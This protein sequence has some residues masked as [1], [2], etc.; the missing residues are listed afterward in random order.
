MT[1]NKTI[2]TFVLFAM[3]PLNLLTNRGAA[4][5]QFPQLANPAE[6][7]TN[8]TTTLPSAGHLVSILKQNLP[9]PEGS[10]QMKDA[11]EWFQNMIQR[12]VRENVPEKYVHDKDWG[13]TDRRWDGLDITSKGPLR[14]TTKRK[15]KEVNH[16]TW[17]R[18]EIS[19]VNPAEDLQ[20]RIENVHDA[21]DGQVAFEVSLASKLHVHG[22]QAEWTKGVQVYSV[23]ADADADV[24]MRAWCRVGTRLDVAKFPPDVIISPTID[25]ADLDVTKFKL[26]SVSKLDGPM[27]RQLGKRV[28]KLLDNKI[29]EKREQ[30][31][32]KLNRAIAKHNDKM[33]L[34]LADFAA[35]KWSEFAGNS[36]GKG[37][38]KHAALPKDDRA[39]DDA[40]TM[41]DAS[42]PARTNPSL[43]ATNSPSGSASSRVQSNVPPKLLDLAPQHDN[44]RPPPA[45]T[46]EGRLILNAPAGRQ[47]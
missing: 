47:E 7:V 14:L 38:P 15:W 42:A 29:E 2:L 46:M 20:I 17:R 25:K 24:R 8:A 34:S 3:L 12:I 32:N 1:S 5:G 10:M 27:V 30:L 18:Y 21:G 13:K 19:P 43:E 35:S 45:P 28:H 37:D 23:S 11:P 6:T 22:R 44:D 33:R 4:L 36:S 39:A 41:R 31:P 9:A 40:A 16:G 26:R